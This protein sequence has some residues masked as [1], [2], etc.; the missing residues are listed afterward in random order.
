MGFVETDGFTMVRLPVGESRS[1]G[2]IACGAQGYGIFLPDHGVP[3]LVMH[4]FSKVEL[5]LARRHHATAS[6]TPRSRTTANR[7]IIDTCDDSRK[8]TGAKSTSNRAREGFAL[9][10]R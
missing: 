5:L 6:H 7:A 2:D 9:K 8:E 1:M 3:G 10:T 4:T